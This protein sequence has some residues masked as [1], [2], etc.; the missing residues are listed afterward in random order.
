VSLTDAV[1]ALRHIIAP[2]PTNGDT[3]I[4]TTALTGP[5]NITTPHPTP[6]REITADIGQA[7]H[8]PMLFTAPAPAL[9]LAL[10]GFAEG[11]L[12][13][14]R[15]IPTRLLASGFTFAHPTFPESLASALTAP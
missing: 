5:L 7:L 13:S 4:D 1:R 14:Q 6:N 15:V 10:G 9:R 12:M 2:A 3:E 8:R 11:I